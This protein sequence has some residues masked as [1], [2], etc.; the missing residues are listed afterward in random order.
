M[1]IGERS[2]LKA[3]AKRRR[4]RQDVKCF[5]R[6]ADEIG[7]ANRIQNA[8]IF[9]RKK[10]LISPTGLVLLGLGSL[11]PNGLIRTSAR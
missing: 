11:V 1:V 10:H 5:L 2:N 9:D 8:L 4:R 6:E 3:H 7:T